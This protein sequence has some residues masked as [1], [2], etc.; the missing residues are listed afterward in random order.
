MDGSDPEGGGGGGGD[1]RIERKSELHSKSQQQRNYKRKK[2]IENTDKTDIVDQVCL[3]FVK[4]IWGNPN[5][6][7]EEII[8]YHP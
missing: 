5:G 8:H 1:S 4:I 7:C 3:Q 6:E 2:K